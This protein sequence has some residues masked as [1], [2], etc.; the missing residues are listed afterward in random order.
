[1]SIDDKKRIAVL[2]Y[3]QPRFV[4]NKKIYENTKKQ[5]FDLYETDCFSHVWF[6]ET[7]KEFLTSSWS[8]IHKCPIEKNSIEIINN[9]YKPKILLVEEPKYFTFPDKLRKIID[10]N[11]TGKSHFYNAKNYNNLLSQ[12][13]SIETIS[14]NFTNYCI[15]NNKKYD[16][17][18]LNRYDSVVENIPTLDHTKK[19]K[20]IIPNNHNDFPDTIIIYDYKFLDWSN[21]LFTD[22][23]VN[24]NFFIPLEK[25]IP[26]FFKKRSFFSRYKNSDL[27]S[28]SM[29]GHFLRS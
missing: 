14:R 6:S 2:Y 21:N 20:F 7:E 9:N 18:I 8:N 24:E 27:L 16:F 13:Y 5:I 3:G 17:I 4:N 28:C 12:L 19:E 1:M 23:F 29:Y 26:E 15:K 22:I 25:P 11:F 10:N